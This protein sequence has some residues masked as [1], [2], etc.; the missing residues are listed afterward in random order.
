MKSLSRVALLIESS[1]TYGRELVRGIT[2]YSRTRGPWVFYR[3]GLFYIQHGKKRDEL[4]HIRRWNPIGIITRDS[5]NVKELASWDVPLFIS[6]A[7]RPPDP[8]QNNIITNDAEIGKMAAEYFL[9]RG[10]RNFGY[11]GFDD[12]FWSRQRG[13]S[14]SSRIAEAGFKTCFYKQPKSLE[15]RSWE[16]EQAVIAEWLKG[17]PK[18]AAVMACND[19][20]GQQITEICEIAKINVPCEVAVIGVDNDDQVCD[21]SNPPLSSVA[22][23]VE[24]AGFLAAELLDR[25]MAGKEES[26]QTVIVRPSR[27]V[28]R[29][30]TDIMAVEDE[31]VNQAIR[32][33]RE[34]AKEPLQIDDIADALSV[35]R[36]SLYD[37]FIK[38]LGRSVHDEVKRV[39]IELA[40]KMLLET[41]LSILE[42]AL[43]L[44]YRDAGHIAR[45]FK[46]RTGT[47]P[48]DFRKHHGHR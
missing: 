33:I 30:S 25:I 20:R 40:S 5:E 8:L 44:G 42:I 19:D 6:V 14:F 38:A 32:F 27:I 46:Q 12:M 29:Q 16:K 1:R 24:T 43:D 45:Y 13:E 26:P 23:N 22:L 39:R 47:L 36:R 9:E 35:N 3:T 48:L 37:R 7:V 11:C 34:N 4:A 17:L 31:L 21:I 41:D 15:A 18:P 2:R 28:T 10:F